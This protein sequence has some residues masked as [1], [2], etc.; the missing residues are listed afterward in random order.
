MMMTMV[1]T[2]MMSSKPHYSFHSARRRQISF[3]TQ[4]LGV[5]HTRRSHIQFVCGESWPLCAAQVLIE[6]E[7]QLFKEEKGYF[8]SNV[9]QRDTSFFF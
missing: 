3:S 7:I 4:V 9:M 5:F 6:F 2:M 8:W 1:M